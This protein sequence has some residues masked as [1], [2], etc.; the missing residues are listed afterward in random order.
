M[1]NEIYKKQQDLKVLWE[2]LGEAIACVFL[3]FHVEVRLTFG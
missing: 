3:R 2:S 1:R